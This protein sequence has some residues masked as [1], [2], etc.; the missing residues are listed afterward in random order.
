MSGEV[1]KFTDM[2][3]NTAGANMM[4]TMS[5]MAATMTKGIS[6]DPYAMMSSMS[7]MA[8]DGD[9]ADGNDGDE[10]Q[11]GQAQRARDKA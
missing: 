10:G 11:G 4:S 5:N 3:K 2:L 9:G 7:N 6:N 1:D 8:G